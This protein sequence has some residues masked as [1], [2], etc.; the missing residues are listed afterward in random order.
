[1]VVNEQ[2]NKKYISFYS[3]SKLYK[4]LLLLTSGWK[5]VKFLK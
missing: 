1:M 5:K 4:S 3:K 2:N